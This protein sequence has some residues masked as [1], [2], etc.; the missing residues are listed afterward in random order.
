MKTLWLIEKD[1][2]NEDFDE[3]LKA[4]LAQRGVEYKM[5]SYYGENG[6]THLESILA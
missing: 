6:Q 4:S 1:L 5:V 2:H 3:K